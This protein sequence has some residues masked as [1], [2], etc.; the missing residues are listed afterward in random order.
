MTDQRPN[1]DALLAK[2]QH[3]QAKAQRGRLKLFFGASAGVGKTYAML[4]AA[5]HLQVQG[6]KVLVGVV[7]T[8]GRKETEAM[9][10]GLQLLPPK[11]M[12][13][14]DHVL[15]EFDL[16]SALARKPQ[17]ILVD[18]LAHSNVTGSR[19]PKRWQDIE[20]LLAAGIDV[21]S[22]VN[23]QH[24]ETL[25]DIVSGITGI[26]VWET[27]P[28]RVFDQA[29]EIVLVDLPPDELLQRLKEGKIYLPQQAERAIQNFFRK[30]NLIALRE[31]A[32][33]RTADRV[34]VEMQKYRRDKAVTSLWKARES[35]LACISSGEG[36]DRIVRSAARLAGLLDV[37]WHV[38]YIETPAQQGLSEA[39]RN[40]ILK[41][42]KSAQD[43]GAETASLSGNDISASIVDYARQHNLSILILG[44]EQSHTRAF[45][46]RSLADKVGALSPDLDVIQVPKSE[47]EPRPGFIPPLLKRQID[48]MEN[49]WQS[50]AIAAVACAGVTLISAPLHTYFD[51][52]NIVMLFLLTVVFVALKLGRGPAVLASFLSV[53]AFDYFYVPPRWS[54]AVSDVQ[55]LMTFFIMLAVGLIIGQLT[56]GLKYQASIATTRE[57]R[58][59]ALYEMSR[60]LSGA[61]IPEQLAE[62]CGRFIESQ[63]GARASV[64]LAGLDDK[65]M[66]P[67]AATGK[68]PVIDQGI[69]QWAFDH[70]EAAGNG[71][72]TLP[73]SPVLYLPL[74]APM[75]VRGVFAFEAV[76]AEH[77]MTPEQRRLLETFARLIAIALER[78]H[79]VDIAQSTTVKMESERLRNSLLSA[80]SHD[81]RTPLS[82]L[83]GLADT[84]ALTKPPPTDQQMEIAATMRE[85][86]MRMTALVNNL[87]DMARLQ[88][89]EIRLNRQWHPLEEVV[90]NSLRAM[91][92]SLAHHKITVHLP[93]D[94]PLLEMDAVLMERVFCNLLENAEK[95]TPKASEIEIGASN[96]DH[97]V[98]IWVADNGPGLPAGKEVE[99]FN[100][101]ERGHKESATPGVGLGLA[102]CLAVVEAHSGNIRAENRTPQGA[103]FVFSLPKG[104]PPAIEAEE[105]IAQ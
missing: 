65:L 87:L 51:L 71:T 24:L 20:E 29:D 50:Y 88:A 92:A 58:F 95:Y 41:T 23:V 31:L 35:V 73:G 1:P 98:V 59:R 17:L 99:V 8:H 97:E 39:K 81:L 63:F 2:V 34:D 15:K 79:Y 18:E 86:A 82:V 66:P 90:E 70:E 55:Y 5:R 76:S 27:V 33:R 68:P 83:V 96:N 3:E 78:I 48:R 104:N 25:N 101:F 44:R 77:V 14:R 9:T 64:I 75:R 85:E 21:Y 84:M 54:F 57:T 38:I 56:A 47:S 93:E 46:R 94:L 16:E 12:P 7:E 11:E 69:A 19:H 6:V 42:L 61:L 22:T 26:N 91:S 28:D 89:G 67:I 105:N 49:D 4:A 103:K 102:I 13:Y 60:D 52:S 53:G 45:F 80:I 62:I 32:L 74:K 100:K 43:M 10:Q 72:D 36:A 40:Q 37:P 30:G